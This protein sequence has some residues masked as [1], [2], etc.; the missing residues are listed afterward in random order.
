VSEISP[1]ELPERSADRG[2]G[3]LLQRDYWATIPQSRH[4]PEEIAD[5]LAR[6]F[7]RFS[8]EAIAVFSFVQVPPLKV[9]DE[10]HVHIRGYGDCHVRVTDRDERSLT[11]ITL[12]DHYEAGRITFGAW[13]DENGQIVFKIRSRARTRSK[14]H[15][16]SFLA[17]GH[18]F[19]KQLWVHFVRNVALACCE[20][21]DVDVQEE[22]HE[23]DADLADTGELNTPTFIA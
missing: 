2:A 23:V 17:A 21:N 18:E 14:P 8:P 16:W 3:P 13:R 4:S 12:E 9:G 1:D 19:Q 6:E 22:T 10:I 11:L 15:L 5:M 20:E 7:P